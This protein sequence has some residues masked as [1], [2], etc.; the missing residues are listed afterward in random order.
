M[1][2]LGHMERIWA[3][4]CFAFT[5]FTQFYL[6]DEWLTNKG[7]KKCFRVCSLVHCQN[8]CMFHNFCCRNKMTTF[9][10]L[11]TLQWIFSA[12]R[13]IQIPNVRKSEIN[14]FIVRGECAEGSQR[15]NCSKHDK[16]RH[17]LSK[18]KLEIFFVE[19]QDPLHN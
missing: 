5:H 9:K 3:V 13:S 10:F 2:K 6:M 1:L 16:Q 15:K 7:Q 4:Q 19:T 18:M 12:R 11:S 14:L 8:F 17:L